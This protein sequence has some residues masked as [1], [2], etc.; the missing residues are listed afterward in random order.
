MGKIDETG[1]RRKN[2]KLESKSV[3]WKKGVEKGED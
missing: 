2:R 1:R 3:I